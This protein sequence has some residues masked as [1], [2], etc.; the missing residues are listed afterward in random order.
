MTFTSVSTK[1]KTEEVVFIAVLALLALGPQEQGPARPGEIQP[2]FLAASD[3][4]QS[5][6]RPDFQP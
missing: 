2:W 6:T 1:T 4:D 3:C 5:P